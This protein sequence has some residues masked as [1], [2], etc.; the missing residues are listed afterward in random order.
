MDLLRQSRRNDQ[1]SP[2]RVLFEVERCG[3]G[4]SGGGHVW[5]HGNPCYPGCA[6]TAADSL[7]LFDGSGSQVDVSTSTWRRPTRRV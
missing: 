7:A 6:R 5:F 2:G 4:S 3:R 1:H